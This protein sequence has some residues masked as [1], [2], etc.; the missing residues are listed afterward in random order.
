L[1]NSLV[2]ELRIYIIEYKSYGAVLAKLASFYDRAF[3]D[4]VVNLIYL[5]PDPESTG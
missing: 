1:V 2:S 5:H 4:L 3:W